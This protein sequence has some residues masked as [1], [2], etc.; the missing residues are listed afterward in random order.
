MFVK[1]S[2]RAYD[3]RP[4]ANGVTARARWA[5]I[6]KRLPFCSSDRRLWPALVAGSLVALIAC[7]KTEEEK[8]ALK[9]AIAVSQ[10]QAAKSAL[11]SAEA[12]RGTHAALPAAGN[13]E[14]APA[15]SKPATDGLPMNMGDP[16]PTGR[17]RLLGRAPELS[18][19]GELPAAVGAPHL[20]HL[21]AEGFFIER[22]AALGF[23]TQQ[24]GKLSAIKEKAERTYGSAQQEIDQAEQELWNLTSVEQPNAAK[25]SDK[26][27]EIAR[28][29]AEQRMSFVRAVGSAVAV[30]DDAQRAA[31]IAAAPAAMPSTPAASSA[32]SQGTTPAAGGM[33]MKGPAMAKGGSGGAMGGG[34]MK[35][36]DDAMEDDD[37][38]PMAPKAPMAPMSGTPAG[39]ASQ[40]MGHM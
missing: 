32:M 6:S 38:M 15:A 29:G 39:G 37:A 22:A 35:M 28:L 23:T 13:V 30:L 2:N 34:K 10:A 7:A 25:I 19:A 21:G 14:G 36:E 4:P 3:A 5:P 9:P 17:A 27:S 11:A 40:G 18:S 12:A 33:K 16:A 8:A 26:I 24:E 20:Y 1:P 31:V